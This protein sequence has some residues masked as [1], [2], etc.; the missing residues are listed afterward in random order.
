MARLQSANKRRQSAKMRSLP[1]QE[2]TSKASFKASFKALSKAAAVKAT[3]ATDDPVTATAEVRPPTLAAVLTNQTA[4][5][6]AYQ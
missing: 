3:A 2:N 5:I 4:I 6:E 1:E